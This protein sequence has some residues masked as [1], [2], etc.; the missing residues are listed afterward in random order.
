MAN[1]EEALQRAVVQ[2]LTLCLPDNIVWFHVPNGEYRSKR[3][4]AKLKAMGVRAGVADLAF[5]LPEGRAAF[6]E[7]KAEG[8][9]QT[10][11][12]RDF[13]G[14]VKRAGGLYQVCRSLEDVA[15]TLSEWG[16]DIR[17]LNKQTDKACL[18]IARY[19]R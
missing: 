9:Y 3:T 4:G 19:A 13:E 11:V 12:Q 2:L 14:G 15:E 7:L 16:V 6:I 17:G 1:R 5:V 18:G 8:K 10:K